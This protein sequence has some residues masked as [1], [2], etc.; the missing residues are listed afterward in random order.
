MLELL[1]RRWWLFVLRGVLA[2]LFGV[3]SLVWPGI[4]LLALVI[5]WGMYALFDGV[6]A[7]TVA[8][9]DRR[10]PASE[11]WL[12][13][14]FGLLGVVVGVLALAWPGLTAVALLVFIAVWAVLG[15][16]LQLISAVRLRNVLANNWFLAVSGVLSLVLGVLLLVSPGKGALVLV[17][18][19]AI[20]AILWGVAL[21]LFGLRLRQLNAQLGTVD[22]LADPV[23]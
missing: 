8:V 15:G 22:P 18:T 4:T 16:V 9:A 17:V 6:G 11:R 21:V 7:V 23:A 5:L 1:A 19:I 12:F 3:L 2:A 10:S 14:L 20:F 13:A